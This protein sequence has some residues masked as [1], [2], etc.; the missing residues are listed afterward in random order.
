MS[1]ARQAFEHLGVIRENLVGLQACAADLEDAQL[2]AD[3]NGLLVTNT[4]ALTRANELLQK[5]RNATE[6][7]DLHLDSELAASLRRS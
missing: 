5:E 2:S 7:R 3:V 4:R 1:P 6:A